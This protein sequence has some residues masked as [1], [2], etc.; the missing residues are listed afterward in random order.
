[1]LIEFTRHR[2]REQQRRF[3]GNGGRTLASFLSP[4]VLTIGFARR[5]AAYKRAPMIFQQF[6]RAIRLFSNPER[7]IQ[8]VFSGKSHPK[9]DKGKAFI[10]RIVEL[11]KHPQFY[12]KI[13]FIENYDINVAR[14]MVAGCD[15]WL[16]N[17]RRPLEASGTS[18]QKTAAHGGLNLSILDGWWREAFDGTNGFAIGG[19]EHPENEAEQDRL[20]EKNLYAALENDVIPLFY[21]RDQRGIP[22][23]W[24]RR[25]R[26]AMQTLIPTFNTDRM[27]AEYVTKLY[28]S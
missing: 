6:E 14:F 11:S 9:D 10:K 18:G 17:P 20:D 13:A 25:I 26:R 22:V 4:D 12:G 21:N 27:V 23:M 28:K 3:G 8:I 19:D 7:P 5:F 24:I 15:V 2:L 16:N 1:M